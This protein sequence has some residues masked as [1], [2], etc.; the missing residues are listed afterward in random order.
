MSYLRYRKHVCENAILSTNSL[1]VKGL[2]KFGIC[3]WDQKFFNLSRIL[4]E[5]SLLCSQLFSCTRGKGPLT[6]GCEYQS[7]PSMYWRHLKTLGCSWYIT[8]YIIIF[9]INALVAYLRL[10]TEYHQQTT[11]VKGWWKLSDLLEWVKI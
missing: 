3:R 9:E 10:I 8:L 11:I 6:V 5:G 2:Y 7:H 1:A 4:L